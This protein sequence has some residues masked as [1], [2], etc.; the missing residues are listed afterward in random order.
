M[1]QQ[2]LAS[3]EIVRS[4]ERRE[5]GGVGLDRLESGAGGKAAAE[6]VHPLRLA[7]D[8]R[9]PR[10][11]GAARHNQLS[12]MADASAEIEHRPARVEREPARQ[13][14]EVIGVPPEV[15]AVGEV[16]RGM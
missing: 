4:G 14:I 11:W 2:G 9:H 1:Q 6:S 10:A 15:P 13:E 8:R 5:F 16:L 3:Y 12:P 7:V